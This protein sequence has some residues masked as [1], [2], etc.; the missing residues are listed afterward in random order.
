M[1]GLEMTKQLKAVKPDLPIILMVAFHEESYLLRAIDIGV[2]HFLFKPLQS[3]QL[4]NIMSLYHT[5]TSTR[6]R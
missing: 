2:N 3:I 1:D 5:T 6:G 4:L